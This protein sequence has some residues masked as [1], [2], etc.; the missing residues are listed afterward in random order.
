MKQFRIFWNVATYGYVLEKSV[1]TPRLHP[2]EQNIFIQRLHHLFRSII[3]TRIQ[4][5]P[6]SGSFCWLT[7]SKTTE[8]KKIGINILTI[9]RNNCSRQ[10]NHGHPY[11]KQSG[12]GI[13][14]ISRWKIVHNARNQA[15]ES[16]NIGARDRDARYEFFQIY[17]TIW[18]E[19]GCDWCLTRNFK[20]LKNMVEI[21]K[22]VF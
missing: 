6:R 17:I 18:P 1:K 4:P 2:K 8:R 3:L 14:K 11:Y 7:T 9:T 22:I 10:Q 20:W 19:V 5:R 13:G 16:C 15:R 12:D 21:F